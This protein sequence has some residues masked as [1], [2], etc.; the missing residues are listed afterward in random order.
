MST[1][2]GS[3]TDEMVEVGFGKVHLMK[4][5]TGRPLLILQDDIGS[6]GWLPFYGELAQRFTVYVPS[7]PGF[8][9]SERPEWMRDVR[10]MAIAHIWLLKVLGLDSLPVVGIGFGGWV[11]A[12]M[13]TM[14]QHQFD[15]MVLVGAVGVQPSEGE[16]VDQFLLSGEEYA[17]LCFYDESKFE[18]VYGSETTV[19]QREAWEINREMAI[20]I[21]WKPYMF[22]QA[23]PNLLGRV[24]TP[25]LVVTGAE[26]KVVPASCGRRYVE[27]LP[28]ARGEALPGAGH[29]VDV[30]SPEALA[31]LISDF[32][33][34]E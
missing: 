21:A 14:C 11:A 3:F 1:A 23:L 26:D 2:T 7:H 24:E 32:V 9:K 30:E 16:I 4:A 19:D 6:P 25:T 22:N 27:I 15:R 17:K 18:G 29:C 13:A 8:G 34:S 10:D 12:E 33:S 5:G 20:R 31:K 28:N